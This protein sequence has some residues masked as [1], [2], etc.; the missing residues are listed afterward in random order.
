MY[1]VH[2]ETPVTVELIKTV[3]NI[4]TT[5]LPDEFDLHMVITCLDVLFDYLKSIGKLAIMEGTDSTQLESVC[6]QLMLI[7]KGEHPCQSEDDDDVPDDEA[8]ASE[9]EAVIYDSALEVLV[10]LSIAFGG[11]F[12]RIFQS[13][14]DVI[15]AQVNSKSKNKRIS[16]LGSLAEMCNGMKTENPFVTEMLQVFV[17]KLTD[18]KSSEVRGNAAYGVGIVI[19]I[20]DR[21]R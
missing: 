14:K 18:D 16:T 15:L 17:N 8:D 12:A 19:D 11:E 6:A 1:K 4:T 7:L 2:G 21:R 10:S 20:E 3:R 13:F 5:I 9:T